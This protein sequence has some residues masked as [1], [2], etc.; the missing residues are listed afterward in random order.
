MD[1][2]IYPD[3]DAL[4]QAA[5]ELFVSLAKGAVAERGTFSVALSGGDSPRRLYALLAT[6]EF[7]G[8]ITW[9]RVQVFWGD[10]R[11]VP[12]EHPDS[13]Y[14][15]AQT[16]LLSKVSLPAQNIHRIKCEASPE[17]T[18]AEYEAE[19]RGF[20]GASPSFDLVLLG[21]GADGHTASLFPGGTALDEK[22]RWVVAQF[23]PKLPA[24]R[25]TLTPVALNAAANIIIMVSG[26]KK[27]GVIKQVFL[28]GGASLPV[29]RIR[30]R[31]GRL[32][33]LLEAEAAR[34][35]TGL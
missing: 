18:A 7:S 20:F 12:P 8:R 15:L 21:V 2:Q 16:Q 5:A 4:A 27:A 9:D 25:I 34:F 13:N 22:R 11:C 28:E 23:L 10:E 14:G 3:P 35:L 29:H 19:L 6:P 17:R 26:E 24:W 1:Y 33:W 30:P 31:A 32:L